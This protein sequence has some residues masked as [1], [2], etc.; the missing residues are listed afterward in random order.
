VTIARADQRPNCEVSAWSVRL[1]PPTIPIP[2]VPPDPD[3]A[4]ALA[5]LVAR[6]HELARYDRT[7]DYSKALGLPL[8]AEDLEWAERIARGR[9][10]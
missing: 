4:L 7:L 1:A 9:Q 5:P 8:S 10:G 2:L 6:C 3:I